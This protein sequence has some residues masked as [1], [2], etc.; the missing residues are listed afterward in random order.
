MPINHTYNHCKEKIPREGEDS[1]RTLRVE[2]L[3]MNCRFVQVVTFVY[4]DLQVCGR[5]MD[6]EIPM[7]EKFCFISLGLITCY[8]NENYDDKP[9]KMLAQTCTLFLRHSEEPYCPK[10]MT[11]SCGDKLFCL[12]KS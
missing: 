11:S 4:V 2:K 6:C 5:F 8:E 10:T 9:A 7:A 3:L 1:Y 12:A